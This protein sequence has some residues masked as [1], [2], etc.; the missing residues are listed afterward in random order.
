MSNTP[1]TVDEAEDFLA[2]FAERF[3]IRLV[4]ASGCDDLAHETEELCRRLGLPRLTRAPRG[5][6]IETCFARLEPRPVGAL[7]LL[8]TATERPNFDALARRY[9]QVMARHARFG[10][11]HVR[12]RA[13]ATVLCAE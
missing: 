9:R 10:A 13:A 7:I 4:D 12:R 3:E 11:P 8:A 5:A 6:S 2:S 1:L